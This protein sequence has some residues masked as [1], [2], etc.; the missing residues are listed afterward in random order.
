MFNESLQKSF[1]LLKV[2]KFKGFGHY[3]ILKKD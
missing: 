2:N 1:Q 3:I